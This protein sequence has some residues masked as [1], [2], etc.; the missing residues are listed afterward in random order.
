M[1]DAKA[2]ERARL[3][4]ETDDDQ[5]AKKPEEAVRHWLKVIDT[6]DRAF[7]PWHDRC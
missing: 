2:K 6:Y 7:K 4:D 1:E 5:E 3:T